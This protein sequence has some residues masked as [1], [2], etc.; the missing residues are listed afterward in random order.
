[1]RKT[2]ACYALILSL[3]VGL[4]S[5]ICYVNAQEDLIS[6]G[7]ELLSELNATDNKEKH[8]EIIDNSTS[9]AQLEADTII[10]N[11]MLD[12]LSSN[13]FGLDDDENYK[14][15]SM[16]TDS[17]VKVTVVLSDQAEDENGNPLPVSR[18]FTGYKD[19]GDRRY[20]IE[21]YAQHPKGRMTLK[22]V[23]RYTISSSGLVV[24]KVPH[25]SPTY[26]E[27][28]STYYINKKSTSL[29][30]PISSADAV[31][32]Y[33]QINGAVYYRTTTDTGI[34]S[35]ILWGL[36][37]QTKIK[38]LALDKTNKRAKVDE[39]SYIGRTED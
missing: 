6:S 12:V 33:L 10:Q 20:T 15:Y 28:T 13:S 24:R 3:V 5:P 34:E 38:L 31:N 17:N 30:F 29:T 8:K 4:L 32:E 37:A 25:T 35:K 21:C 2:I 7:E 18:A 23:N 9:T 1:M 14:E 22:V 26:L 36:H 27:T 39:R 16:I 19:Y 11:E